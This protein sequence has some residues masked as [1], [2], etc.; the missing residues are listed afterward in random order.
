MTTLRTAQG[1]REAKAYLE[2]EE[3]REHTSDILWDRQNQVFD[4]RYTLHPFI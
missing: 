2:Y 3:R 4:L 1:E